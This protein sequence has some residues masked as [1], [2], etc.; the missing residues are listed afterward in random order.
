MVLPVFYKISDIG[1]L[2]RQLWR[3]LA[4]ARICS[5][6]PARLARLRQARSDFAEVC[7]LV[8][9]RLDSHNK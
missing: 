1:A 8:G 5:M 4:W 6:Q 7:R 2:Q 9:D 3:Q